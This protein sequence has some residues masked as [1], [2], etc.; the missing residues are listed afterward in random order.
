MKYPNHFVEVSSPNGPERAPYEEH[1]DP[2]KGYMVTAKGK[3]G[4]QVALPWPPVPRAGDEEF[5][6]LVK[7]ADGT[8]A[9]MLPYDPANW[10]KP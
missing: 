6:V 4:R 8:Q 2:A 10:P 3:N 5:F 7:N 1:V 9:E